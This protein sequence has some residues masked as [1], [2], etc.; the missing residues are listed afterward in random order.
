MTSEAARRRLEDLRAA[1]DQWNHEYFV[2]DDPTVV[3]AAYDAAMRELRAIEA[4]HPSWVTPD[5]PSQ[6]VGSV[7]TAGFAQIKHPRPMLSL[8]NVFN[9]E[10]LEGWSQRALRFSGTDRLDFVTEA[11]IDGLAVALTYVDGI[12]DHGATRGDGTTGDDITANLRTV[13]AI[14]LRLQ[15]N[16][17]AP[18][19]RV[20]VR[21]ELY[22]RKADFERLNAGI[23]EAGGKAFMNPRN[24]AAGSVRQKDPAITARRP[25][26][27]ISYGIGYVE[28]GRMPPTHSDALDLLRRHG[29]DAS[30]GAECHDDI[31]SVWNAC[32]RWQARRH[33]LPHEIDGVVVKVNDLRQQ[34]EIGYVAREPRWAT[35]YKFPAVQQTTTVEEIV[36]NV[37]RTG[38]L[39]PLARLVP[40]NIGGVTVSR[41]TLHNEDE[42][43][44]K[45]IR[46]GDTVVVQRAGDVI[47][48]IVNVIEARRPAGSV[49]WQM[50]ETCP[51]CGQPAIREPDEAMRY[52]TNATCPAQRKERI[53]HFV[54]RGAMDI[55]GLGE[56]LADGF[57][58]L[59]LIRDV[60]DIYTLDVTTVSALEGLGETSADNL[61]RAIATSKNQPLW[62]LING[63]GIRHVG[64]RTARLLADRFGSLD[65]LTD[66]SEEEISAIS[67]I[68]PVVAKAL[69]DFFAEAP[70][71]DLVCR[72][73][74]AGVRT[75]DRQQAAAGASL[76][77]C[78]VVL[79][80]RLNTMTRPRAEE[81][82]RQAGANVTSSVSKKTTLLVAGEDAGSKADKARALDVPT[83]DEDEMIDLLDGNASLADILSRNEQHTP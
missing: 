60:A 25:L 83:I 27:F 42:I 45:D 57:V 72:L 37:G 19:D 55:S 39:N 26:R 28:G 35:A 51:A 71:R 30:P 23:L 7:A 75:A 14:P 13:R 41:A 69:P 12:F 67:G 16:G 66:A 38:S 47:P 4:D 40:V 64:E 70:N 50:P 5:S 22:M 15:S 82:L 78:T 10:E 17:E 9:R 52:C 1:I 68:G 18:P 63:L 54:S 61:Q 2:L 33:D 44:R 20:E 58:D 29:F 43:A 11:K 73:E 79:T 6:R 74:A 32:E 62:R 3:D 80:G 76:R 24:S 59:E 36:V 77:D 8:S 48:Q 81:R 49:R 21:G 34:D 65:L 46:V 53:H 56:K 31:A